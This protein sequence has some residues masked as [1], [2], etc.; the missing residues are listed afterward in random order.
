[1]ENLMEMQNSKRQGD[2]INSDGAR[3]LS[4]RLPSTMK[5]G[6]FTTDASID[7]EA[8]EQ[9]HAGK[10][11]DYESWIIPS[12]LLMTVA[13]SLVMALPTADEAPP[14]DALLNW[15]TD[16][17]YAGSTTERYLRDAVSHLYL[18]LMVTSGMAA[19]RCVNDFVAALLL[20]ANTPPSRYAK[21]HD[22]RKED[23]WRADMPPGLCPHLAAKSVLACSVGKPGRISSQ[24]SGLIFGGANDNAYF[25]AVYRLGIGIALGVFHRYGSS[26]ALA[27]VLPCLLYPLEL[28]FRTWER[29][30]G[31]HRAFRN[32]NETQDIPHHQ[33]VV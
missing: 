30:E 29:Y 15:L 11:R 19:L 16:G 6:A 32:E 33:V 1:M 12:A 13:F 21:M 28:K 4:Q 31:P 23:A 5:L 18:F 27:V 7:V 10:A 8:I 17:A 3:L 20:N 14:P 2:A 25:S 26:H 24:L 9:W 22:V